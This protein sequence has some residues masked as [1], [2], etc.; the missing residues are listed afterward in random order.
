M[1][2]NKL[3]N[4]INTSKS[5]KYNKN[6]IFK[7]KRKEIKKSLMKPSKKEII[8]SIIKKIK[9]IPYDSILDRDEKIEEIKKLF[10]N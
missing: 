2:K 3:I 9:E 5:A 10:I 1:S 7:S 4:A 6:N 8:K